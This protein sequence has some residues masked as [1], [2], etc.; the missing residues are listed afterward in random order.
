VEIT[1]DQL[2]YLESLVEKGNLSVSDYVGAQEAYLGTSD[3][4]LSSGVT[5][6][7]QYGYPEYTKSLSGQY[8]PYMPGQEPEGFVS[9]DS[10]DVTQVS[11]ELANEL[12]VETFDT[13]NTGNTMEDEEN[14]FEARSGQVVAGDPEYGQVNIVDYTGLQAGDPTLPVGGELSTRIKDIEI[15]DDELLKF[16]DT[17][18]LL[19]GKDYVEAPTDVPATIVTTPTERDAVTGTATTV[20]AP[21]DIELAKT[22]AVSVSDKL[23]DTEAARG[24]VSDEAL[25]DA[26]QMDPLS[27][28]VG[29]LSAAQ[30]SDVTQVKAPASRTLQSGEMVQAAADAQKASAFVEQIQAAQ[31]DPSK[32]ATVQGQL[33]NLMKDF[34]EGDTP[35]WAAGALRAATAAMAARGLGSSSLA[36]QAIVQAAMES[37]LPIAQADAATVAQFESQ[38]LS[39]RQQRA[40]LAAQQRAQFMGQEFDQQFQARVQNAA[41]ISDIA[42]INFN[43]EQQIALENARLAQTANLANLN[44]RQA[45]VMAEA[46]QIANLETTNLNNRQQAAVQNA[47]AFLQMDFA[48]LSNEQQALMFDAEA[49]VQALLSDQ[50]AENTARNLNTTEENRLNQF[51]AELNQNAEIVTAQEMNSMAKFNATAENQMIQ[52]FEELGL[53]ADT[54]NADAINDIA[55]F[56]SEQLNIINQFNAEMEN[57]R[58]QFNINNQLEIDAN[59]VKWRRDVNTANT[60]A[61]NAANQFDATN[62]LDI[63]QSALNNIWQHYD[64]VLN[65]AFTAEE[66][67]K[68]RAFN[69]V[70][71]NLSAELQ[72]KIQ[73]DSDLMDLLGDGIE[74]LVKIGTSQSS[75]E[76][77]ETFFEKWF[78]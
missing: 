64:T 65:Y 53:T 61:D 1:S 54:F 16:K 74:G 44:N 7:L 37:A 70:L 77:S 41:K 15:T 3:A 2:Q 33:E 55:K 52:F 21:E 31:A 9:G 62:L 66:S 39:N 28:K 30:I 46:A 56:N 73:E 13:G 24:E 29:S 78:G 32:A 69:L 45:L 6:A 14:T 27:T 59:N 34:D 75:G 42:N 76:D 72:A 4:T 58:E 20:G 43:A 35:A 60:A 12:G 23:V 26:A 5:N 38:N 67:E 36:G 51:F 40:M 17:Y 22:S 8:G 18:K 71:T 48:N 63:R 47:Q 50:A 57:L 49:R 11:D 68:E 19:T 10:S 25:V